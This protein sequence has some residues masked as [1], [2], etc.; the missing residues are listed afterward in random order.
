MTATMLD[1]LL[2]MVQ[3]GGTTPKGSGH[4]TAI[5]R[6]SKRPS[7]GKRPPTG[8]R[9]NRRPIDLNAQFARVPASPR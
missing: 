6:L 7:R 3:K 1:R 9:F 8:E 5:R 4:R 2:Q